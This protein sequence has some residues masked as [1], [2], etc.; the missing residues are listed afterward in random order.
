MDEEMKCP[1]CGGEVKQGDEHTCKPSEGDKPAEG[2]DVAADA[3][4]ESAESM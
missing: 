4:S 2:E 1:S 3:P